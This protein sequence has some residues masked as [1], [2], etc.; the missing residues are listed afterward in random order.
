MVD[1]NKEETV[2]NEYEEL[3]LEVIEFE[4]SDIVTASKFG[5][6]DDV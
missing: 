5:E 3:K 2:K 4:E 6:E 1:G